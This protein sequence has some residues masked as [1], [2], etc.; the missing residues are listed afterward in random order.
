MISLYWDRGAE[1]SG[2]NGTERIK[3][4]VMVGQRG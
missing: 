1:I 3:S 2:Y 4:L